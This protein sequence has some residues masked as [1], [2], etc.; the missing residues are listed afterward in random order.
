VF[1]KFALVTLFGALFDLRLGLRDLLQTLLAPRQFFGDRHPVGNVRRVRRL[2]LGQ[3]FSHFGL[4]LRLDLHRVLVRKRA[5]PAGVGVNLR[6]VQ[7]HR[8]HLQDAHLA[9]Q[10]QHFN[11]QRFNL[12]QKPPTE[13]GDGV[14]V[15]M[16]VGGDEAE[17][18]AVVGRPLQLA[19]RK[20][21]RRV[22]VDQ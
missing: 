6:A 10:Q 14:V 12:L 4:Q 21:T 22:A 19:T 2:G 3:Q 17:R 18:H 13:R 8:A 11:E 15:G 1:R 7:R 20:H 5:V 9:R 16:V